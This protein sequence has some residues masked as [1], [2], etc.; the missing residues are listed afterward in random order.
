ME[1]VITR[2]ASRLCFSGINDIDRDADRIA[3]ALNAAGNDQ[4][5]IQIASSLLNICIFSRVAEGH[6]PVKLL[7]ATELGQFAGEGFADAGANAALA[8]SI[9]EI[10]ELQ[11]GDVLLLG[12]R[13]EA[14]GEWRRAPSRR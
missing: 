12:D 6:Y 8:V 9:A 1:A 10:F 7:V 5:H 11:Y 4:C 14:S 13:V 2:E 3:G